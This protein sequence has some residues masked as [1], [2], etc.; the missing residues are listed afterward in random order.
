VSETGCEGGRLE[1]P[2]QD[3]GPKT[4]AQ[5]VGHSG[6]SITVDVYGHVAPDVFRGALDVLGAALAAPR[7]PASSGPAI[8]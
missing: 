7:P 6:I 2:A 3:S 4:A 5:I 1:W 8:A